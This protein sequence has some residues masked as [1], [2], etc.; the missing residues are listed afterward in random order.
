M[1]LIVDKVYTEEDIKRILNSTDWAVYW[2]EVSE[3]VSIGVD[4]YREALRKSYSTA[5]QR[6]M[7]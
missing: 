6:V 2:R 3:E 1:G 5:H 4:A 7:D